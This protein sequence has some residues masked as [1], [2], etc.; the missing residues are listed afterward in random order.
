MNETSHPI[1]DR[2]TFLI[3]GGSTM[4]AM[5]GCLGQSEQSGPQNRSYTLTITRPGD[6]LELKIEPAGEVA[7]VIQIN[8]GDTVEFTIINEAE[9]PV[10]FHNHANDAEIVIETGEQR[11][12]SFEATEAMT[13]RQ[14]IE[15]WVVEDEHGEEGAHDEH[16][17]EAT[18]LAIIE[19]RPR[20]S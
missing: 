7:D 18:S 2:R 19:V 11:V 14:E 8:V 15:G 10:G 12:M 1:Y 17:G 4:L 3:A 13:G 6:T 9:V 16:G 5:A 20:G